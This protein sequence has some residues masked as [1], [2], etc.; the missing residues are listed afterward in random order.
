MRGQRLLTCLSA[1]P[2]LCQV[3]RAECILSAVP[4]SPSTLYALTVTTIGEMIN[5][6]ALLLLQLL[7]HLDCYFCLG[8]VLRSCNYKTCKVLML[9]RLFH[10]TYT[11]KYLIT[12]P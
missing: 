3:S 2:E 5:N 8:P 11:C 7:P 6:D 10:K 12:G 1:V 4:S 9:D